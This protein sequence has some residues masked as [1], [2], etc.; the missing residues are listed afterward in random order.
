MMTFLWPFLYFTN[1]KNP[2]AGINKENMEKNTCKK[3]A[4][5]GANSTVFVELLLGLLHL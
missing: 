5:I 2:R 4:T 3:G 1:D